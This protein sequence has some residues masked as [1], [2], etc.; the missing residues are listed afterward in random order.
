MPSLLESRHCVLHLRTML[1]WQ[2]I[3]KKV[4][5]TK[6]GCTLYPELC[7]K[8]RA[9]SWCSTWQNRRTERVP[10][11]LECLEEMLQESWL[12]KWTFYKYSRSISQRSSLSW[13]T[14]RNRM[15]RTKVQRV[16][17]TCKRRPYVSSLQRNLEDTKDNGILPWTSQAKIGPMRL[18]SDFRAAVSIKNRLHREPG[19]QVEEPISPEQYRRWHP[20]SSTSWWSLNG[21]GNELIR[22]FKVT[23]CY[24]WFRLQSIA[25]HCDRRGV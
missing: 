12:S 8:E 11:S 13:I 3:Q 5:Q 6:S 10:Y 16:G 23:F 20:S 17:C 2:R 21:I 15:D 19:E 24:S 22:F 14:T 4:Y 18:R 9:Q 7:D 25:I 1:D